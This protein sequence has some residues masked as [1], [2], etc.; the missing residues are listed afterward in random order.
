MPVLPGVIAVTTPTSLTLAT[1]SL[2]LLQ[3]IVLFEASHGIIT[4]FSI[5]VLP[6]FKVA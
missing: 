6:I 3:I 2:P 4:G 1:S 5:K